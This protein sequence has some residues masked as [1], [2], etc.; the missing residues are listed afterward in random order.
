MNLPKEDAD[1]YAY[2]LL[3]SITDSVGIHE[4]TILGYHQAEN[5]EVTAE[6]EDGLENLQYDILYGN[7]YCYNGE[8]LYPATDITMGIDDVTITAVRSSYDGSRIY[9]TGDGFT[10]WSRVYINGEK[11]STTYMS[12]NQLTISASKIADGDTVEVCQVGSSSTIFRSSDPWTYEDPNVGDTETE[13][14]E[15]EELQLED[16][17]PEVRQQE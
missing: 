9:I 2:Q 10:K 7:R 15:P 17:Q 4:G 14:M 16:L 12:G 11:V 6:Y 1:L 8:D 3:A 5:Y 13:E